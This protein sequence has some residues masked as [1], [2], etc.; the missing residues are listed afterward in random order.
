MIYQYLFSDLHS[1][2]HHEQIEHIDEWY[3]QA[4]EMLDF[5][6]IA[7]YPY[8][9]RE[10]IKGIPLEDIHPIDKV[11]EDWNII[12]EFVKAK[13]KSNPEFPL[14]LGYEWQGAGLD[15]DHNVFFKDIGPLV[16]PRRY[17]D[18][19]KDLLGYSVIAV[20]HHLAYS[21]SH[22]GKNWATHID[23]FSP[24]VEIY[25]SHGSS[26]S[27]DTDLPMTRH[28]HMGPRTGGTSVF[29]GLILGYKVGIIASGDNHVVPAQYGHGFAG[30]LAKD[31]SKDEIWDAL[32]KRRVYGMTSG[33]VKLLYEINENVMGSEFKTADRMLTHHIKIE[34][35][36]SI[37]RVVIYKNGKPHF[38]YNYAEKWIEKP[39]DKILKFKFKLEFGWGPDLKIYPDIQNKIWNGSLK[40]SGSI[41]SIEKCWSSF[42]QSLNLLDDSYCRFK[43]TTRK[44]TQSGKWMGPSPVTTEGFVFEIEADINSDI[45]IE[46]D[47]KKYIRKVSELFKNTDVIVFLEESKKLA[48]ER[49]D[50]T[51]Y[52]RS[53]PFYHNA[54][55]VRVNK[56]K[57][58]VSYKID[59]EFKLEFN[60]DAFYLIKVYQSDGAVAWSS[61]IWVSKG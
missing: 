6:A 4:K 44:T 42:G 19:Y 16:N 53:D 18:L 35:Q 48:K 56:A 26:E 41:K 37:D 20:P 58:E 45:I 5:W 55:K 50:F 52:Y 29:D 11:Q 47:G 30:I 9:I 33:R 10:D 36:D 3:Q 27:A 40:T 54:Y 39:L 59:K 61:P 7:Y 21:L 15:G 25:S 1:N 13:N 2:I 23:E 8:Y 49:F 28:V 34:T 43:L 14:F 24:V 32:I 57:P 12:N 17:I 46:I 38:T 51:E 22:R 31:K 60:E